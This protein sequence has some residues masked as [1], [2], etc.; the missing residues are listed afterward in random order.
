ML[1]L[2]LFGNVKSNW[3]QRE[4]L[5]N[6]RRNAASQTKKR[7]IEQFPVKIWLKTENCISA[8]VIGNTVFF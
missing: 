8:V 4:Y 7:L 5:A 6:T 2:P 3:D 1:P